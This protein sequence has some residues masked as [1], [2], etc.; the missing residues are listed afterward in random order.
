MADAP[1]LALAQRVSGGG[2]S[3][4][5]TGFATGMAACLITGTG[6]AASV[7]GGDVRKGLGST[8][9]EGAGGLESGL[10]AAAAA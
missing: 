5:M 1:A 10:M 8:A 4:T 9:G 7:G 6:G 3:G 2:A